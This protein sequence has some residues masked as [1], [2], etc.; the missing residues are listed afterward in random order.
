MSRLYRHREGEFFASERAESPLG[1]RGIQC[2]RAENA[3]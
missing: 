2:Q 1:A 3:V